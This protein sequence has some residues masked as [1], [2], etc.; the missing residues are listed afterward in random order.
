MLAIDFAERAFMVR[1]SERNLSLLRE[2]LLPRAEES[3]QVARAGY[4]ANRVDFLN[5]I[6]AE[7][8]LLEF[9]LAEVQ[10]QTQRELALAELSFLLLAETP[11]DVLTKRNA[12]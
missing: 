11:P 7:R 9:Q 10:A 4:A 5:L 6:D 8:T 2:R 12:P 1:E 3:L